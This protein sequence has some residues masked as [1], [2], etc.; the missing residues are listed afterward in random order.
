MFS[1]NNL[2]QHL[3][4]EIPEK[5]EDQKY[6]VVGGCSFTCQDGNSW[7]E[8]TSRTL[9]MVCIN[10]A[11]VGVGNSTIFSSTM[12]YL[13]QM[14]ES[15]IPA[16][17]IIV[18]VMWSHADRFEYMR[19][20]HRESIQRKRKPVAMIKKVDVSDSDWVQW[21][22]AVLGWVKLSAE[23]QKSSSALQ[24][25]PPITFPEKQKTEWVQYGEMMLNEFYK[26]DPSRAINSLNYVL[27]M[28]NFLKANN[29]KYVFARFTENCLLPDTY[30]HPEVVWQTKLIDWDKF[31]SGGCY[32]WCF[33]NTDLPFKEASLG[34][35][36]DRNSPQHPTSKQHKIYAEEM[37]VPYLKNIL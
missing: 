11:H 14:L 19:E 22:P 16:D 28:Q 31:L 24:G 18:G 26:T 35:D 21:T 5:R 34:W 12:R 32:E 17:D 33:D 10:T 30:H 4:L 7:P 3:E 8:A 36:R 6:L 23:E 2:P 20:S 13:Q 9:D 37:V 27:N 25:M 1:G 15:G 29:I